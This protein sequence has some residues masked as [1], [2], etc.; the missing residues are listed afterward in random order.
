MISLYYDYISLLLFNFLRNFRVKYQESSIGFKNLAHLESIENKCNCF[1]RIPV[2][3]RV[4][5]TVTLVGSFKDAGN[6]APLKLL[7]FSFLISITEIR[8]NNVFVTV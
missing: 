1:S 4:F 8:R 7:V 5:G 2:L 3:N 6:V